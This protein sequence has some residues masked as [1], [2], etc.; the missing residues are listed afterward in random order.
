MYL[1]KKLF[2]SSGWIWT[3]NSEG[4]WGSEGPAYSGFTSAPRPA[5]TT[6]APEDRID[7]V[8]YS[9]STYVLRLVFSYWKFNVPILVILL[10]SM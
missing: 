5:R 4:P 8:L 6:L 10:R 7:K 2:P 1:V 9:I 3:L